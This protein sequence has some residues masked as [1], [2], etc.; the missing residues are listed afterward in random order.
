MR[1]SMG[2]EA[3]S[4]RRPGRPTLRELALARQAA[5]RAEVEGGSGVDRL[6]AEA[7]ARLAIAPVAPA[8]RRSP[9]ARAKARR[10]VASR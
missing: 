1:K 2:V 8:T 3:L 9:A 7:V 6:V 5:E 10:Q 4:T